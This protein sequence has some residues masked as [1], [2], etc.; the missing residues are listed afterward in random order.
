MVGLRSKGGHK[1]KKI[2]ERTID[3]AAVKDALQRLKLRHSQYGKLDIGE[4]GVGL[5]PLCMHLVWPKRLARLN[6]YIAATSPYVLILQPRS[7]IQH[8]SVCV[9]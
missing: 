2:A 5:D 4:E 9:R 8:I 7:Q 3:C 6:S 1:V